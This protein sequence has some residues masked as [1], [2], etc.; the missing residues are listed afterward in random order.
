MVGLWL[1]SLLDYG[2]RL[3]ELAQSALQDYKAL[4]SAQQPNSSLQ[5]QLADLH[6]SMSAAILE[7]LSATPPERL[8]NALP[9]RKIAFVTAIEIC[10]YSRFLAKRRSREVLLQ[11]L[12]ATE[13]P[14]VVPRQVSAAY[15]SMLVT[16]TL[17]I[18]DL[19]MHVLQRL[20]HFRRGLSS[21]SLAGRVLGAGSAGGSSSSSSTACGSGLNDSI[22]L[23]ACQCLVM[24]FALAMCGADESQVQL[25]SGARPFGLSQDGFQGLKVLQLPVQP[26][27]WVKLLQEYVRFSMSAVRAVPGAVAMVQLKGTLASLSVLCG[28]QSGPGDGGP[29][30]AMI[31]AAG[32]ASSL[33]AM[34]L[35]G[36]VYSLLKVYCST[37]PALAQVLA[38]GGDA[39]AVWEVHMSAMWIP[40]SRMFGLRLIPCWLPAV[41]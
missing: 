34:Q 4:T 39:G 12:E 35:L 22:L 18:A 24:L 6:L 9:G 13:H 7:W 17:S 40:V 1:V 27:V 28:V 19:A 20:L 29:L 25:D 38:G 26:A 2:D 31:A 41:A 36:L 5:P 16:M 33:D 32:D 15:L 21:D 30:L 8:L 37:A 11:D 14:G 23:R 3:S 10:E